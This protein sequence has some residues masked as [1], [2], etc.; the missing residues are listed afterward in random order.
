MKWQKKMDMDFDFL[1]HE[2]EGT[3]TRKYTIDSMLEYGFSFWV[4]GIFVHNLIIYF[5]IY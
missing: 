1:N 4:H 3:W 5:K 2:N